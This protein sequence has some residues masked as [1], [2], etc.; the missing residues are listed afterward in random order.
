MTGCEAVVLF[1]ASGFIGRNI[2]AALAGKPLELFAVNS[3]GR[4]VT[5]CSQ[6]VALDAL[7]ELPALPS[8]TVIVHTAAFRYAASRFAADQAVILK[9][10]TELAEQVY[11]FALARGIT[12]V[13]QASSVAVYPADWALQDDGRDLDLNLWPHDGEAAYAWSKRWGEILAELWHRRAGIN[14]IAFRLTNPYGPFDTID[15]N[16][17]HVAT[18]FLLRALRD[19]DRFEIRGNAEAERDF[20]FAGDVAEAFVQSLELE[21]QNA[22]LNCALGETVT[23]RELAEAA[24]EATGRKR[25]LEHTSPP[26]GSGAGVNIRRATAERLRELLPDLPAFQGVEAG[27][28]KSV[29]WYRD[30]LR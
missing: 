12:E 21:G 28:R 25:P 19:D 23:I 15:E 1:G 22:S 7:D 26:A 29:D 2:V 3:N 8:R 4:A 24:M 13:R 6:T 5:G 30:A 27:L 14:T 17:A 18:A 16:E 11:G 10:N 20:V 9:T